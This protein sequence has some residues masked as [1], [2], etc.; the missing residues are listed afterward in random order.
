MNEWILFIPNFYLDIPHKYEY[1]LM[2]VMGQCHTK[3]E[4]RHMGKVTDS[5]IL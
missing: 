3:N 5:E 1:I 4:E 2:K